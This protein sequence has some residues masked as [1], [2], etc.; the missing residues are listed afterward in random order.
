LLLR[1]K[2]GKPLFS[3]I[4][5][6]SPSSLASNPNRRIIGGLAPSYTRRKARNQPPLMDLQPSGSRNVPSVYVSRGIVL[7]IYASYTPQPP[8][9]GYERRWRSM[10]SFHRN[11]LLVVSSFNRYIDTYC[12]LRVSSRSSCFLSFR[13]TVEMVLRKSSLFVTQKMNALLV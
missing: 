3:S 7:E 2:S 1:N 11:P 10:T 13:V 4:L 12:A 6:S 9:P 5:P 8:L